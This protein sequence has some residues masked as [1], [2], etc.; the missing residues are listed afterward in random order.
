MLR[1]VVT[2]SLLEALAL[3]INEQRANQNP[4]KTKNGEMTVVRQ[5]ID[6]LDVKG[7]VITADALHYQRRTLK[8]I[9]EKKAH[10]VVQ[11][12]NN[13]PKLY[14][15]VKPQI[16]LI[17]DAPKEKVVTENKQEHHGRKEN[18]QHYVLDAP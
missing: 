17:F 18:S 10:I 12:K 4:T 11:V 5:P 13:Q 9:A 3:W 15:A 6:I 7:S 1:A 16:Q 2:E 8:K 14:E